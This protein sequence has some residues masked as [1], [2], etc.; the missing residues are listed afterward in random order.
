MRSSLALVAL[1]VLLISVTSLSRNTNQNLTES[2]D[3]AYSMRQV[4][5]LL[6]HPAQLGA[7]FTEKQVNRL[8]DRVSIALVKILRED[9]LSD[10]RKVRTFLPLIRLAFLNP[11]LISIADDRK[12]KVTLFLLR[13]LENEVK[14]RGL[15]AEI[16]QLMNFV[17][18][19]TKYR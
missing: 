8:G 3:D 1:S 17:K 12:P 6:Q 4:E 16:S 15:K 10:P 2:R 7:G 19:K 13:H 11:D 9:E 5:N 14:D 18:E